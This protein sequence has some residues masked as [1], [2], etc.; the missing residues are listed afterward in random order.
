MKR[1]ITTALLGSILAA[2][3]PCLAADDA[4]G[5]YVEQL[6]KPTASI[7]TGVSYWLELKRAGKITHVSNR[8]KF[9]SGDRLRVFV[10]PNF[11][12]YAY[13]LMMQ[14]S[15]GEHSV[16]FPTSKFPDNK[17]RAGREIALPVGTDG[18]N[19]WLKFDNTPGNEVVRII[20]SRK[21]INPKSQFSDDQS[22]TVVIAS[23][24]GED[25][26]PDGAVVSVDTR[27]LNVVQEHKKKPAAPLQGHVVTIVR[28]DPQRLLSIDMVL[29]HAD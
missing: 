11:N 6:K 27:N 20:V 16:L 2:T 26:V 4:R 15:E 28:H 12:G 5:L 23:N 8:T 29:N 3:A 21:P 13:I 18:G 17:V 22:D 14:S 24:D 1:L 19:A 10:K 7:N 25:K 9:H